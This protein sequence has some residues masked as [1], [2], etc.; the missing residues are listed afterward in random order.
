MKYHDMREMVMLDHALLSKLRPDK[1]KEWVNVGRHLCRKR[2]LSDS[3]AFQLLRLNTDQ[4]P[5]KL[6]PSIGNV[7]AKDRYLGQSRNWRI[8]MHSGGRLQGA[9]NFVAS[10][11]T[12]SDDPYEYLH[13]LLPGPEL[14]TKAPAPTP[15]RIR[16]SLRLH[17]NCESGE[18]MLC[19]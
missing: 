9:P 3:E 2:T 13:I 17:L 7:G 16:P 5:L 8:R 1:S 10:S 18:A 12:T 19:V 4:W 15:S 11:R 6:R 14:R